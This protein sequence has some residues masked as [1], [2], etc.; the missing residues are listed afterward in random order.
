MKFGEWA[1]HISAHLSHS[2]WRESRP[3]RTQG[4]PQLQSKFQTS[5]GSLD[6]FCIQ[7]KYKNMLL[8]NL[9]G[10]IHFVK[11]SYNTALKMWS[12]A[13]CLFV[14]AHWY[15]ACT[16]LCDGVRSWSYTQLGAAM[17]MLASTHIQT[18]GKTTVNKPRTSD[19][20]LSY[21]LKS[22]CEV[23][24]LLTLCAW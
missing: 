1:R 8:E 3:P 6:T 4:E 2:T 13:S 22:K 12:W 14:Y 16:Y 11:K 20:E 19:R 21:S 10:N 18:T 17:W 9:S 15:S 5:S 24:L 7:Q 23:I